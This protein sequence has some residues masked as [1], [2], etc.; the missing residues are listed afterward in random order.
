[1]VLLAMGLLFLLALPHRSLP[2]W[3][4][5]AGGAVLAVLVYGVSQ[6]LRH[7]HRVLA[8]YFRG[9]SLLL[10]WFAMLRL[11]RFA[12]QPAIEHPLLLGALLL[13]V[14]GANLALAV[15]WNSP[16]TAAVSVGL[17]FA[18][19]LLGENTWFVL[20]G[21]VVVS[22]AVAGIIWRKGWEHLLGEAALLLALTHLSWAAGNPLATGRTGWLQT[23]GSQVVFFLCA[24]A[25]L[26]TGG[27][28]GRG[29]VPAEETAAVVLGV[30]AADAGGLLVLSALCL[31]RFEE[32]AVWWNAAAFVM[33]FGLAIW[34]W[35]RHGSR[36][37]TFIHAMAGH[38]ALSAALVWGV[39]S[40]EVL[41]WLGW[42]SVLVVL[43]AVWFRSRFVAAGN[44]IVYLAVVASYLGLAKEVGGIS[45]SLG[46]AAIVSAEIIERQQQRLQLSGA[47]MRRIYLGCA[48]V[49]FPL[50]LR[51]MLPGAYVSLSWLGLAVGYYGLSGWLG[52][53]DYRWLAMATVL[54]A[55]GRV[56]LVD[57]VGV[58]PTLRVVS[59][60]VVGVAL[61]VISLRYQAKSN[62]ERSD[63]SR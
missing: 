29:R 2:S 52:R 35:L 7:R 56:C 47:W 40:T 55:A 61:V 10:L 33:L 53:S 38:L 27:R 41:V 14:A 18:S 45:F 11:G 60:L 32:Q 59:F 9:G 50:T 49:T 54:L 16:G 57:L 34:H 8:S 15:R 46:L 42:Q 12:E 21:E 58:E 24:V 48:L 30:A 37:L 36:Y 13:A 63:A 25:A 22:C 17:A 6:R 3:A 44:L 4:P 5:G 62:R 28:L 23:P 31:A 20:A 19:V 43:C 39:R 51:A 1:M 26:G